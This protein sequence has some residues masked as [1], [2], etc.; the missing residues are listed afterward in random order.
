MTIIFIIAYLI[1]NFL[2][3]KLNLHIYQLNYYKPDTQIKWM[4]KNWK[5]FLSILVLN[6]ISI[7]LVIVLDKENDILSFNN[8]FGTLISI[9]L[10]AFNIF[11]VIE[12][13]VKKKIV[14]TSRVKRFFITNYLILV[15]LAVVFFN[16]LN[17]L[18]VTLLVINALSTI[19]MI[20]L[21]YLNKPINNL[22]NAYYVNDAKKILNSMPNL[23]MVAITGSYG[24][25]S[26]KNYLAKILAS[27]Y[28]V[29]ATPGN[30]NTKLGI[31]RTVRSYLKPTHEVFVCEVGIDRKNDMDKINKLINPDYCMITAIGAQHLETFKTQ[32]NIINEKLKIMDN[33]KEDG[34]AFLNLDNEYLNQAKKDKK[35]VGYGIENNTNNK[36]KITRYKYSAKGIEFDILEDGNTYTFNSKLLGE[37]NLVNLFGAITVARYLSVPM[38]EIINS[39]KHIESVEHRLNLIPGREYN[40]IDDS[41]N[42]NPIGANNAVKVLSQME[43][44]RILITPGMVELGEKQYE[45]NYNLGITASKCAD[46]IFLVNKEQT[47]PIYDALKKENYPEEKIFV[48]NQFNEAMEKARKI[49]SE[50]KE[51]YILIENDLPDNY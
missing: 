47:K 25:T 45:C 17:V 44:L 31:T 11:L 39:V 21:D 15:I 46:Y 12:R 49:D 10:L 29:L 18:K 23:K 43:G 16:N 1:V 2:A 6:I 38:K 26:T 33:L 3:L 34:I 8:M 14:Y 51:K 13:N 5:K 19:Y 40:L 32:E 20:L 22:I 48:V 24:K 36:L 37:H 42:S 41:Y 35:Y 4:F 28:N 7:I 9:A 27:K 30:F 50:G